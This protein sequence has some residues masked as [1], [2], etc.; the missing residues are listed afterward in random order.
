MTNIAL[1]EQLTDVQKLSNPARCLAPLLD[2]VTWRGTTRQLAEAQTG[3]WAHL[4]IRDLRNMMANLNFRSWAKPT[5]LGK[6]DRRLLPC[7]FEAGNGKCM[8][9]WQNAE[10]QVVAYD[11]STG[12][13]STK[14]RRTTGGTAYYFVPADISELSSKKGWFSPVTKRF[15][16]YLVQLLSLS[17]VLNLLGLATPLFV[18]TVYDK[19]IGARS[20]DTLSYLAVGMGVA[21]ACDATIRLMRSTILSYI[22]GRLDLI[23][24]SAVVDKIMDMPLTR[25]EKSTIGSQLAR[26]REFEGVRGFFSGPM[27]IAFLE[28]PFLLV[29]LIAIAVIGGWLAVVPLVLLVVFGGGAVIALRYVKNTVADALSGSADCQ[30]VLVEVLEN[31]RSIKDEGTE[32][33]WMERFRE[34][35]TELALSS[36]RGA[37]INAAFQIFAQAIMLIAGATTLAVGTTLAIDGAFSTGALIACMALVWR[38]LSPLQ[39]I[40]LA[41]TRLEEVKSAVNRIDQ[42]MGQTTETQSRNSS[43]VVAQESQFDG[44]ITFNR[45]VLRYT[46][47][48]EPALAGVSF[49]I[50]PGEIVAF[51]GGNGSGKSTIL[52]LIADLYKAQA[53]TVQIDGVDTRQLNLVDLR[54]SIGYMPQKVD[55]FSGSLTENLRVANPTATYAEIEDACHRAGILDDIQSFPGGLDTYL[56]EQAVKQVSTGFIKGLSLARTLLAPSSIMMFDEPSVGLDTESD[57]MLQKQIDSYRGTVTTL[58]VT[59]RPDYVRL[60]DRVIALDKGRVVFDGSPEELAKIGA[61][62]RKAAAE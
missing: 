42:L 35:S 59:H 23:V 45:V 1:I 25:L 22:G 53:G 19:V 15:E 21:L 54:Q 62:N 32:A 18:M 13:V 43:E 61:R 5:R 2:A 56:T 11:A 57:E 39:T 51:I 12:N 24:N 26:L 48:N 60:A 36:L 16:P 50:S 10:G 47:G 40:F 58:L 6:V 44:R 28:L 20:L 33:I 30:S 27:A 17:L 46:A 3:A 41:F 55:F 7:V 14:F 8:V 38:V 29:Y 9:L 37:R 49:D 31:I 34:R 52:K 4:D